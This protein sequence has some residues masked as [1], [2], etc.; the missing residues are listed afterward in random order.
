MRIFANAH[1]DVDLAACLLLNEVV[2]FADFVQG[3]FV[4]A[5][6]AHNQ[7]QHVACA[8]DVVVVEQRA[9]ECAAH[10]RKGSGGTGGLGAAHDGRAAVVQHRFGVAQVN[11]D[12]VVVRDDFGDS[13]RSRRQHF[14]GL[15]EALLESQVSVDLAQLVVVDDDERI[16]VLAKAFDAQFRLAEAHVALKPER[17]GNDAHGEDAQF[18]RCLGDHGGRARSGSATHAGRDEDHFGRRAEG[19]LDFGVA[20]ERRLLAHFGIGAGAESFGQGGSEL[21]FGFN[22]AVRK[23]LGVGVADNE[24]HAPNALVLHVVDG[25][26]AATTYTHHLDGRR[27]MLGKVEI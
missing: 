20:L 17:S 11:V 10:R 24:V 22:G 14:V 4:F 5:A 2:D 8:L 18:A 21:D 19:G 6:S 12:A 26:G 25:I 1:N 16:H 3:N 23:G 9:V 27:T 7:E 13:A 15:H